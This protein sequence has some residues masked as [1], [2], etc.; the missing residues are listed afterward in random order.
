M[1]GYNAEQIRS[2]TTFLFVP[3]HRPERFDKAAASGADIVVIDL[4]DA[5]AP[6]LK[7]QAREDARKWLRSDKPAMVR[8][9]GAGTP[10]HEDDL[11]LSRDGMA[12]LMLPKA[13]RV[14]TVKSFSPGTAVV[15][16]VE[17]AAGLTAL[18]ELCA[19]PGVT[20][21]AFGSVDLGAELG[22][23]PVDR[24]ALLT[25]RSMLVV[26]SAA[27]GL[28]PPI[29]GVTTVLNDPNVLA[30]DVAYAGRLGMTGKLC[31]HPDQVSIANRASTPSPEDVDWATKV[32]ASFESGD[33]VA[34]VDGQMVDLPVLQRA[35]GIL[36]AAARSAG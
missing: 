19:A 6:A 27:A 18:T 12:A 28:P 17:T 15:A 25:A 32:V 2:A 24:D 36:L 30:D 23:D 26:A 5:V 9:N 21:L 3:G 14:D 7:A 33:S 11:G 8:I 34:T 13:G 29:D 4:E 20:R 10:W 1:T 22:V 16:L 31:I 35:Q